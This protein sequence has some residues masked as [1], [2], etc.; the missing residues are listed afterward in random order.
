MGQDLKV[1]SLVQKHA[2]HDTTAVPAEEAWAVATGRA[3]PFL[4]GVPELSVGAAA[5]FVLVRLDAPELGPGHLLANLV[6]AASGSVVDATV[7][8]GVVLMR[9]GVID[10]ATEIRQHARERADRLGVL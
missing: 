10:G 8:D 1:F 3:A 9:D 6:Y 5:D 7:V 4:G 2:A